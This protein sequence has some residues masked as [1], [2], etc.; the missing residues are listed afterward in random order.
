VYTF[1]WATP[2]S[3]V[4]TTLV[5]NDTKH[6]VRFLDVITEFDWIYVYYI[7]V[8]NML[9]AFCI[10]ML[11]FFVQNKSLLLRRTLIEICQKISM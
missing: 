10:F 2:Y 4:I 1:F 3:W 6:S 9:L 7:S 5:Y 11:A 8:Y